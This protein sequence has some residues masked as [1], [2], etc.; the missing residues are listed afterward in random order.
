M[1]PVPPVPPVI[2]P[3]GEGRP[4]GD[5]PLAENSDWDAV[6]TARTRTLDAGQGFRKMAEHAEPSF[7][8]I[9]DAFLELHTRHAAELTHILTDAGLPPEDN[10]SVM[11]TI[12]RLVVATRALVDDIDSDVLKQIHSGEENVTSAYQDA[13]S[14]EIP[15]TVRERLAGMLAELNELLDDTRPID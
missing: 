15:A 3:A 5:P 9:V 8:P 2:D 1:T 7:A 6:A 10:G 14:A 13:L 12:N 4:F 11:G